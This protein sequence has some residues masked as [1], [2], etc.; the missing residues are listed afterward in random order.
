MEG[1][2][3][4]D[5][6][7][8]LWAREEPLTKERTAVERRMQ[9]GLK[10]HARPTGAKTKLVEAKGPEGDPDDEEGP[11]ASLGGISR[12]PKEPVTVGRGPPATKRT[13]TVGV[14]RTTHPKK[15]KIS[16]GIQVR[17]NCNPRKGKEARTAET[18]D[19]SVL[20]KRGKG[21]GKAKEI[22]LN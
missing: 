18:E 16:T 4:T 12:Q 22:K 17:K 8:K 1:H 5:E 15:R 14:E 19:E 3:T 2:L 9:E 6:S 10:A 11:G 21:Q 20:D 7:T 13:P